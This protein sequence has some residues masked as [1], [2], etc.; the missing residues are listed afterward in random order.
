MTHV[1]TPALVTQDATST[2]IAQTF[3]SA[4]TAGNRV[5][6]AVAWGDGATNWPTVTDNLGNTYVRHLEDYDA[7]NQQGLA[8]YSSVLQFGGTCTVTATFGTTTTF[9]R[10]GISEHSGCSGA[11]SASSKNKVVSGSPT[12][13][14]GVTSGSGTTTADGCTIFGVRQHDNAAVPTCTAGTGF[15][16]RVNNNDFSIEDRIQAAAGSVAATFTVSGAEGYLAQM[17]AFAPPATDVGPGDLKLT[18]LTGGILLTGVPG[19][20]ER[21]T[22]LLD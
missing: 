18:G 3:G 21:L 1:Q 15:T 13:T 5:C 6:V 7:G 2:T 14:D 10:Y 19:G 16:M 20:V 4:V 17:V 9:R 11:V 22:S 8:T 12:S